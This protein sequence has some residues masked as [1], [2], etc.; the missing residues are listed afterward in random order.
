MAKTLRSCSHALTSYVNLGPHESW[1]AFLSPL[2]IR[3]FC[4]NQ[5]TTSTS[6]LSTLTVSSNQC[7]IVQALDIWE[8]TSHTQCQNSF[9]CQLNYNEFYYIWEWVIE[10]FYI[11]LQVEASLFQYLWRRFRIYAFHRTSYD[12]QFYHE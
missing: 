8:N 1:C 5:H 4:L 2:T 3:Q 12:F 11:D 10:I 6:T 9:E 7:S